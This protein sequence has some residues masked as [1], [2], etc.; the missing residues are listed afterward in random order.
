MAFQAPRGTFVLGVDEDTA[1]VG[2]DGAWQVHGRSRAMVW[3][4]RRRERHRPG[5]VFRLGEGSPDTIGP[6]ARSR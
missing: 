6:M 5:D 2:R 3:D 1:L 4:G